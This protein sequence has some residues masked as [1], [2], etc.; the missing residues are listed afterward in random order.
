MTRENQFALSGALDG[1]QRAIRDAFLRVGF[2]DALL[3]QA[4]EWYGQRPVPGVDEL[5]L[6]ESFNEQDAAAFGCS[7]ED[8]RVSRPRPASEA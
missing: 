4:M 7:G 6:M 1:Q 8:G 3:A 2:S 5:R